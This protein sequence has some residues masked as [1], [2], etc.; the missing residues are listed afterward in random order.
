MNG[1]D[2]VDVYVEHN[3][4][5]HEIIDETELGND[6]NSDDDGV[7]YTGEKFGDD[8]ADDKNG[9]DVVGDNNGDVVEVGDDVVEDNNG[10]EVEVGDYVVRDN[11]NDDVDDDYEE[12]L[13][14][15]SDFNEKSIDLD[16]IIVPIENHNERTT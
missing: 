8:V 10:D 13:N 3:I 2:L 16:W 6:L 5:N 15:E 4:D 11:N 9:D 1:F 14:S 7:Q 12:S